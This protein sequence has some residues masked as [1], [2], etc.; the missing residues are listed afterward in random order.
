MRAH[1][2]EYKVLYGSGLQETLEAYQRLACGQGRE[3]PA[4]CAVT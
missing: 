1:T 2:N 4:G 3:D